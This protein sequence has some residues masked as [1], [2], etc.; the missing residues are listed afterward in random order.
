[1]SEKQ[2][3]VHVVPADPPLADRRHRWDTL[4]VI[5]ASLV[6][7][8]ALVVSGYTAYIQR[9]Q[10]RAQ[11]W[12]RLIIG[13]N[14][15]E[16]SLVAINK[17]VGPAIVRSAQV[18]V[19]GKPMPDWDHVMQAMGLAPHGYDVT[20]INHN[21]LTPGEPLRMIH[22]TDE[23]R[24]KAFQ[25]ATGRATITMNVCFCSTLGDCWVYDDR[26]QRQPTKMGVGRV[27]PVGQCPPV[28]ATNTFI[29]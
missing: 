3:P 9:Q 26:Q 29:N 6:G 4:G 18:F 15:V 17:G 22:F 25:A 11:V 24:W 13:G 21:I 10:V 23:A 14:G 5:I 7:L 28:P 16:R 20:T 27:H 2:P 1:M 8:L 19:D 12:P